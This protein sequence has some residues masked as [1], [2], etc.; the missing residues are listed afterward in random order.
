VAGKR[1]SRSDYI[2][3]RMSSRSQLL[4]ACRFPDVKVFCIVA[5]QGIVILLY[6]CVFGFSAGLGMLFFWSFG[7]CM[8]LIAIFDSLFTPPV[9]GEPSEVV[10]SELRKEFGGL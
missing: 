8:L 4:T 10:E 3:I 1:W 6:L 5:G 2:G 7:L 9:P